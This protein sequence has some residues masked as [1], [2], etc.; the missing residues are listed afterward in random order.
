MSCQYR[1]R[2]SPPLPAAREALLI[3]LHCPYFTPSSPLMPTCRWLGH[4]STHS[5]VD[6]DNAI[7]YSVD[8]NRAKGPQR[9]YLP[10]E[11]DR[12][13]AA[14]WTWLERFGGGGPFGVAT[15]ARPIDP[16]RPGV[17]RR[18]LLDRFDQ[19]TRHCKPCRDAHTVF[20][21][22]AK[23]AGLL[24]AA[25]AVASVAIAAVTLAAA[26]GASSLPK[27]T[28]AG[29]LMLVAGT[30]VAALVHRALAHM[31]QQFVFVDYDKL[32]PSKLPAP[33]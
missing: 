12:G 28:L 22:A 29:L 30:G 20:S 10:A 14:F 33:L 15:M 24:A 19:H 1:Y 11:A 25:L 9:V 7:Q 8:R 26:G 17:P 21:V 6:A 18:V 31:V 2:P 13:P 3:C 16:S 4:L 27:A 23:A 32:H 5:L